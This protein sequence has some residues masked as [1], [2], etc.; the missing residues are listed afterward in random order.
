MP[1]AARWYC[2]ACHREWVFPASETCLRCGS[3]EVS[4]VTYE[5]AYPGAGLVESLPASERMPERDD[6][7]WVSKNATLALSSPEFG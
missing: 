7:R 1:S 4:R 2:Q 6:Q 5:A 3:G